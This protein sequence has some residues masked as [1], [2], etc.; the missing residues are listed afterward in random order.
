[1]SMS[2]CSKVG[3][4][5][6]KS[7]CARWFRA[8]A[9]HRPPAALWQAHD[10][11]GALLL[12]RMVFTRGRGTGL[13]PERLSVTPERAGVVSLCLHND[14][15]RHAHKV[16]AVDQP[17]PVGHRACARAFRLHAPPHPRPQSRLLTSPPSWAASWTGCTAGSAR[18]RAGRGTWGS[19]ASTNPPVRRA[20]S[21][22]PN[23]PLTR[24]PAAS[25]ARLAAL[26][27]TTALLQLLNVA[28]SAVVAAVCV[29]QAWYIRQLFNRSQVLPR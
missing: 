11:G 19:I 23:A 29:V 12:E 3:R 26:L 18:W 20:R 1:M 28:Q 17:P 6:S 16:V 8:R 9:F 14:H 24:D 4:A 10:A 5:T 13:L 21:D 25:P 2:L 15:S 7:R 27:Q 22:D